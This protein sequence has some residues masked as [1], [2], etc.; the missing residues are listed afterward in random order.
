M[1][2]TERSPAAKFV[3]AIPHLE[4]I[5]TIH[6]D[7]NIA[8]LRANVMRGSIN[9]AVPDDVV[10]ALEVLG[11]AKA[12]AARFC[13]TPQHNEYAT[14]AAFHAASFLTDV[15]MWFADRNAAAGVSASAP[16]LGE[17]HDGYRAF[18]LTHL[19]WVHKDASVDASTCLCPVTVYLQLILRNTPMED[20]AAA[21]ADPDASPL[22]FAWAW[23]RKSPGI[24]R[25]TADVAVLVTMGRHVN[26]L[27]VDELVS[28]E[29]GREFAAEYRYTIAL[30]GL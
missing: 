7:P 30:T 22:A 29:Y 6:T 23:A 11:I 26:R 19:D 4:D 8:S 9:G 21:A 24:G 20:W 28:A 1:A 13:G 2:H 25:L 12:V 16:T 5:T 18:L 3:D 10:R 14:E 27:M 17:G 15:R